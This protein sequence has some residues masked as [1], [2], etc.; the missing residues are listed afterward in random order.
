MPRARPARS[1]LRL[2]LNL[3][4]VGAQA[5]RA[6]TGLFGGCWHRH[7]I[8]F[9][10]APA[11]AGADAAGERRA[12]ARAGQRTLLCLAQPC[13]LQANGG[14]L[15]VGPAGINRADAAA[16]RRRSAGRN[17]P[18]SFRDATKWRIRNPEPSALPVALDSGL[19]SLRSR[20][21]MTAERIASARACRWSS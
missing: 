1:S 21:G 8:R 12:A 2:H 5:V 4:G 19:A 11:M 6:E 3:F 15:P 16:L 14:R 17:V 7:A 18:P 20:P 10:G 13:G 9:I